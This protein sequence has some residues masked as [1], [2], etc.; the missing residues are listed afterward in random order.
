LDQQQLQ[1]GGEKRS[2]RADATREGLSDKD[3]VVPGSVSVE[4]KLPIEE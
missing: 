4:Y 1:T 3:E 2:R